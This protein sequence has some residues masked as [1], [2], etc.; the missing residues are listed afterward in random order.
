MSNRIHLDDVA[1]LSAGALLELPVDQLDL[2]LSEAAAVVAEATSA[3]NHL[4]G[5]LQAR[6]EG[7]AADAR[8]EQG[9]DTGTVRVFHGDYEVVA[10]L[11]K[12][13]EWDQKTLPR[14][15]DTLCDD[16]PGPVL[17]RLVRVKVELD[18]RTFEDLPDDVRAALMPARTVKTGKPTYELKPLAEA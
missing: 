18:E 17:E 9:K 11:P 7:L 13:V 1:A 2:L 14:L 12:K 5:S 15:L 16:I 3:L 8:R 4:K 10:T 6:F